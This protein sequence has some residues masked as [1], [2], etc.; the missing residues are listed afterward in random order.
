MEGIGGTGRF[1]EEG[2]E[3]EMRQGMK[4]EEEEVEDRAQPHG[5][6]EPHVSRDLIAGEQRSAV[7]NPPNLGG[8][9]INTIID[10]CVL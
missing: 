2:R 7:V 3:R 4:R 5:L 1:R 6:E 10:L 8:Q 9:L